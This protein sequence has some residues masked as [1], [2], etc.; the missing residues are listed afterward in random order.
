MRN[1][2]E[3]VC[4]ICGAHFENAMTVIFCQLKRVTWWFAI[5][6]K[7]P[8]SKSTL[9]ALSPQRKMPLKW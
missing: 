9:K 5:T 7:T 8:L 1:T 6:A 3:I 4:E 2:D